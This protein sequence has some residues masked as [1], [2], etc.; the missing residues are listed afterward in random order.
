MSLIGYF[1]KKLTDNTLEL[2]HI[3]LQVPLPKHLSRTWVAFRV[4]EGLKK[5]K[6]K[7]FRVL[8]LILHDGI[9]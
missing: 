1:T 9:A 8:K 4:N 6:R 2:S 5:R 3:I 7:L